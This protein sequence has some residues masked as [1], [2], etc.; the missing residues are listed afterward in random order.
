MSS[1][2]AQSS[3]DK[4]IS[5]KSTMSVLQPNAFA[6]C[7]ITSMTLLM[8]GL[9]GKVRGHSTLRDRRKSTLG[10]A[11]N[12]QRGL[13]T[14]ILSTARRIV[15]RMVGIGLPFYAASLLGFEEV[16]VI[17]LTV[18]AGNILKTNDDG[19]N[20]SSIAGWKNL[21][22]V[23]KWTTAI[24]A[25]QVI[26]HVMGSTT[27]IDVATAFVG[28][29]ALWLSIFVIPF[30]YITSRP[31]ASIVTSPNPNSSEKT[32]AVAMTPWEMTPPNISSSDKVAKQS[33]LIY[34]SSDVNLTL[35][36]G[37]VLG[38]FTYLIHIVSSSNFAIID[39]RQLCLLAEASVATSLSLTIVEAKKLQ[40]TRKIGYAIGL[41]LA[42]TLPEVLHLHSWTSFVY[43]STMVGA[44][45]AATHLDAR[46]NSSTSLHSHHDHHHHQHEISP[47]Q[48]GNHSKFTGLFL[49]IFRNRP[50]LHSIL[51]ERDS[52]RIFYFMRYQFPFGASI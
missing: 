27:S 26:A 4:V 28:Y 21:F 14:N 9:I 32:S 42:V 2:I 30:P 43:Q 52:R 36:A 22:M 24:M 8:V 51:V 3:L 25:L 15:G 12:T 5:V 33:P 45:F 50:L 34:T 44:F 29:T 40:S 35:I 6:C 11:S 47:A 10:H 41:I 17:M 37:L 48:L 13:G 19:M 31:K 38:L 1:N 20:N 7:T 18:M 16:A 23:R 39:L 46:S 49:H